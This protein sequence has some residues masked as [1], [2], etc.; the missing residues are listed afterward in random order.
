[1]AK[2]RLPNNWEPR[3]YQRRLWDYLEA[4]GKRAIAVWHRRAG[5]D[6]VFLHRFAV[7]AHERVASYWHLLPNSEQGRKAIWT[8]V[9]PHTGLRRIDE[10]F[11]H[12]LRDTTLENEMFIRF[13]CGSTYQVVGSDNY[14]SLVGAPPAGVVFSEWP[15]A[16]PG[17]W[18]FIRPM[19]LENKG[20]AGFAYTPRGRNHGSTLYEAHKGDAGWFAEALPATETGVFTAE[21]LDGERRELI[22][23]YGAEDGEN[24]YRQEY[25]CSFAAGVVGAYYGREMEAAEAEKRIGKVPWEPTLPVHTAWDLGIGDST[26]IWC[27]QLAGREIRVIDYIENSGVGIDWYVRELDK[28]PWKFGEH[29]LPHDAN[30]KELGTGKS[31]VEVMASLGIHKTRIIPAQRVEDGINAARMLLPLTHFDAER[32]ERGIGALQNYRRQWDEKRRTYH[33]RP[34][35]DWASHGADAFRYLALA[36]LKNAAA[37]KP[38]IYPKMGIV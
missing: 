11:P 8:A 3:P 17:A 16:D 24:R 35:H 29:I 33:D 10:A 34:L 6:E 22:K 18:A 14:N 23:E 25:L 26:A 1:L 20:W 32:C 30:V 13:R 4:G 12:E 5:K 37:P 27:V 9:N 31:R 36:G 2:V 19:L 7:A 21:Q 38:L 28:R 15:L